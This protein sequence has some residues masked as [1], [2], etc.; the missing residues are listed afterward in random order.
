MTTHTDD[1]RLE[2]L[3]DQFA[4][5]ALTGLL[6]QGTDDYPHIGNAALTAAHDAYWYA[7]AMMEARAALSKQT[8]P[9]CQLCGGNVEGW[10]CQ[11]CE[12]EFEEVAGLLVLKSEP[13]KQTGCDQWLS[14]AVATLR[15]IDHPEARAFLAGYD[16]GKQ[17]GGGGEDLRDAFLAGVSFGRRDKSWENGAVDRECEYYLAAL[18][19][20]EVGL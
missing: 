12:A 9:H 6:S 15:R 11:T 2:G 16:G 20:N 1:E 7:E 3:R 17:T 4:M 13:S 5:A 19:T 8:G 10:T 18:S 14:M